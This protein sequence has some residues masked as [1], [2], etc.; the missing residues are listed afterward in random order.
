MLLQYLQ[1]SL[2][3]FTELDAIL[4]HHRRYIVPISV[5]VLDLVPHEDVIYS[6]GVQ[7][8]DKVVLG[9]PLL[10][11]SFDQAPHKERRLVTHR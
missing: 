9:L 11:V 6:V 4:G 5:L 2:H 8:P 7:I 1:D 10:G 3:V